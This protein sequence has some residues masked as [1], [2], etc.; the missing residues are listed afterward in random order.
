MEHPKYAQLTETLH[1]FA[2]DYQVSFEALVLAWILRHP[3]QMQPIVGSMNLQRIR[4]MVAA[5]D[6]E[7]SR[8]DWYKIYKSAGNPLP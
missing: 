1:A 8:A 7:L 3:A 6:I 4:S 2:S 5:F